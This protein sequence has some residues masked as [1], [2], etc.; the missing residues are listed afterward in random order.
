MFRRPDQ[1]SVTLVLRVPI[2]GGLGWEDTFV[3]AS[4]GGIAVLLLFDGEVHVRYLLFPSQVG[5]VSGCLACARGAFMWSV[6]PTGKTI[7][8]IVVPFYGV[9]RVI[10]WA[11]CLCVVASSA[12]TSIVAVVAVVAPVGLWIVGLRWLWSGEVRVGDRYG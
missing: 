9:R 4:M 7:P 12:S 5:K 6:E 2:G 10:A 1:S 8:P 3:V 11:L